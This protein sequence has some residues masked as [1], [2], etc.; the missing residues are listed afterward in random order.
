MISEA[1]SIFCYATFHHLSRVMGLLMQGGGVLQTEEC[2]I[3]GDDCPF[4]DQF[5]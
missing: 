5:A 2:R 1:Y 4:S 3:R